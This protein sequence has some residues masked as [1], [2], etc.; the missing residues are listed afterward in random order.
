[1]PHIDRTVGAACLRWNAYLKRKVEEGGYLGK[2]TPKHIWDK[3]VALLQRPNSPVKSFYWSEEEDWILFEAFKRVGNDWTQ[4]TALLPRRFVKFYGT[5]CLLVV[6]WLVFD[7]VLVYFGVL[8][9][10]FW[11]L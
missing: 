10:I 6:T 3:L 4:I 8:K 1:M 5:C 2:Q 7:G 9:V 11:I